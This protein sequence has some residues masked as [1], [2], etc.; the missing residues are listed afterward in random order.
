[1][2]FL[3]LHAPLMDVVLADINQKIISKNNKTFVARSCHSEDAEALQKFFRQSALESTHTLVCK[4]REQPTIKFKERSESALTS[5]SEIYLGVFDDDKIV[6][7][8][9]FRV[10][11]PDHPWIKHIGEFGMLI[12]ADYWG[13]GIGSGLLEIMES[14]AKNI[15]VS[16]VEA[17]VRI[18]NKRGVTLYKNKGYAIEGIR[19]KAACINGQFEDEFFIAKLMI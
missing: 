16:R 10:V 12:S 3:S 17:K 8:L 1:M 6:G 2:Y 18:S 13:Q 5:P 11:A 15:G 9:H 7:H 14:F 4:E 19:K